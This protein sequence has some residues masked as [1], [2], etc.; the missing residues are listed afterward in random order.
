[1]KGMLLFAAS[2]AAFT[3]FS[4]KETFSKVISGFENGNSTSIISHLMD[5]VDLTVE[6][7]EDFCSKTQVKEK[8]NDFFATHKPIS[9][10]IKHEGSSGSSDFYEIGE[11]VTS[12]GSY[13]VTI[14]LEK[15]AGTY[16][17]NQLKIEQ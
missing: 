2:L 12:T 6:E 17:V 8:L 7:F 1:M 10:T 5:E 9:F 3:G 15:L 16:K 11:L 14:F 4:Q 13:R